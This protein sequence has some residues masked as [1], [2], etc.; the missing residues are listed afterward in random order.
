MHTQGRLGYAALNLIALN[1]LK[2]PRS[3]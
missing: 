3:Y 1:V 2:L